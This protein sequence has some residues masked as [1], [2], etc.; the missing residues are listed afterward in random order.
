MAPIRRIAIM[1]LI[2]GAGIAVGALL[3]VAL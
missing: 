3:V 1:C 2:F